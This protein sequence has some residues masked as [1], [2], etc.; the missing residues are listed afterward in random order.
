[1]VLGYSRRLYVE[2]I[3]DQRLAMLLA[4]HQHAFDWFGELTEEILYDVQTKGKVESGIK[5][6]KRSFVQGWPFPAWAALN[7]A[8][9]ERVLTVVDQRCHGTTVRQPAE[10]FDDERLRSHLAHLSYVLQT[11]LLRTVTRDYLVTVETNR[12]S[13]PAGYVG[14]TVEVQWGADATVQ[15]YH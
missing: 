3:H 12:Y 14:Q 1:M 7:P 10:A 2:F 15:I 13:V 11:S 9:Q 8:V 5:Y 6:V 4:C